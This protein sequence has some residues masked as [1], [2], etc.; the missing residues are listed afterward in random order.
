MKNSPEA[1]AFCY[2]CDD[3]K[4]GG[5]I[6]AQWVGLASSL[7]TTVLPI[8]R[9]ACLSLQYKYLNLLAIV[10]YTIIVPVIETALILTLSNPLFAAG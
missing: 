10:F 2:S 9:I 3:K 6:S 8:T 4:E 1:L 7:W 5:F